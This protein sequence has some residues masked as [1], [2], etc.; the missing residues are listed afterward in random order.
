MKHLKRFEQFDYKDLGLVEEGFM[1]T[2]KKVFG[3]L[4]EWKL[5][6]SYFNKASKEAKQ[7][8]ATHPVVKGLKQQ[9]IKNFGMSDKQADEAILQIQDWGGKPDYKTAHFDKETM[10]LSLEPPKGATNPNPGG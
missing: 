7:Y 1:D 2:V 3:Q 8:L 10:I 6:G 9:L 4:K 5:D